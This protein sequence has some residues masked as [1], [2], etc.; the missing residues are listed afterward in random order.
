MRVTKDKQCLP[1]GLSYILLYS[2]DQSIN[3]LITSS[4]IQTTNL[5]NHSLRINKKIICQENLFTTHL[6]DALTR[7]AQCF[8]M[9]ALTTK[10]TKCQWNRAR[11][12]SRTH[13]SASYQYGKKMA[14]NLPKAMQ[15][16]ALKESATAITRLILWLPIILIH[17]ATLPRTS[18]H[19]IAPTSTQCSEASNLLHMNNSLDSGTSIF[20]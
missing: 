11:R 18:S 16:C 12:R 15:S 8:L 19:N 20:K 17:F 5:F 1:T 9:L 14:Y 13:L 7:F 3:R 10:T 6:Q 2:H 4:I